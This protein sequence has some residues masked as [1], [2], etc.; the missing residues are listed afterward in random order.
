MLTVPAVLLAAAVVAE[1]PAPWWHDAIFYE[2]FVRSFADSAEGP[3]AAD[4][5]GDFA[6]LTARLDY[7]N[8]GDPATTSD[9]G[10]NALW[11]MPINESPS[12]HG[13]DIVDYR[14]VDAEYGTP[15]DF[16]AFT[17]AA[18]RPGASASSSTWCSTTAPA[19]TPGLLRRR[20][21]RTAPSATGSSGPTATPASADRGASRSG[22]DRAGRAGRTTTAALPAACPT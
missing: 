10:I 1:P 18:P 16:R 5:I 7:L 13:Y 9:L 11:L 17:D 4:G 14:S 12:Y 8:D 15:E 22:T 2:V 3:L 21:R 6:G 20:H 19:S